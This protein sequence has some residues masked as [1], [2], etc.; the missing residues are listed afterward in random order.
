MKTAV[1]VPLAQE[2]PPGFIDQ[3]TVDRAVVRAFLDNIPDLVYFKDRESRFIAVSKSK[4]VRHGLPSSDAMTGLSDADFFSEAHA[5]RAREDELAIM[6]TGLPLVEK[7]EK[8]VWADG[9]ETWALSSKM[10]LRDEDGQIVGTFGLSRDVT[11]AKKIE[12]ALEKAH[13]DLVHA[14]RLAGM[15]EVATGVL[16]NVGNVLNSLNVSATIIASGLKHSKAE[17]LGKISGMLREHPTDLGEFL[18][19]DPRGRLVPDFIQSLAEHAVEE[20]ARLLQEIQSV[21]NNIDHIKDIVTMQQ[22]YA[23]M[24]GV[25]EAHDPA[26]LMEDSLRMNSA[27]LVR[28]E[29]GVERDFRKT[30]RVLVEKPKVL[31]IL[32]NLIRNGKYAA[33]ESGRADKLMTLRIE[34]GEPGRVRLCV[35]DNGVGISAEN[36]PKLFTHGFTTRNSGHGF[37]L[38]SALLAAKELNGTLTAHSDGPGTGATFILDLPAAP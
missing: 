21:Q 4:A 33:D 7:L 26:A 22:A 30:D 35:I 15:A 12:Q 6:R 1:I 20:R 9:H 3:A 25:V 37:G 11:E 27:A 38:H 2:A 23:T 14:S 13:K 28:H 29:V 17:S 19:T 8:L 5:R 36:L 10:P 34:P 16:H 24:V 18:T 31:Q 32:V